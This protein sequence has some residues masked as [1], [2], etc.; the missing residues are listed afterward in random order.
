[1][2]GSVNLPQESQNLRVRVQPALG[3]TLATGVLLIHPVAGA[4]TWLADK[5][6][7]DPLGQIFAYEYAVTGSWADPK[8]EKVAMGQ[9]AK[10]GTATP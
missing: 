9:D 1:M 8:V 5:L 3:E 7:K 2:K 6:L 10:P 4:I